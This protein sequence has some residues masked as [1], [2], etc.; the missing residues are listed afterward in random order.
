MSNSNSST[1]RQIKDIQY[2]DEHVWIHG[3]ITESTPEYIVI[4][5]GTGTLRVDMHADAEL[6]EKCHV[7]GKIPVGA[8]VRV[9][10]DIFTRT[11]KSFSVKPVVIVNIDDLGVNMDLLVKVQQLEN[12]YLDD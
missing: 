12:T 4:D 7:R 8:N 11:D 6:G 10:G 2:S 3:K 5:D 1:W 9:I